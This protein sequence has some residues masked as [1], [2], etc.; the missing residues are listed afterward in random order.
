MFEKFRWPQI[1]PFLSHIIVRQKGITSLPIG[2]AYLSVER[3]KQ[4][5]FMTDENWRKLDKVKAGES[6]SNII[7]YCKAKLEGGVVKM[8]ALRLMVMGGPAVGKTTMIRRLRS[9]SES[10]WWW[11]E[12]GDQKNMKL[13]ST[14]GVEL[15]DVVLNDG[16]ILETWDFGG[17]K[18]Y[19]V[20][21]QLF[22]RDFCVY[23]VMCRVND[24]PEAALKELRFW[25]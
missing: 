6:A 13:L 15:G 10:G 22:L 2:L 24:V 18:I 3:I 20:S 7:E 21:H 19:R 9:S 12:I 5:Q 16:T 11:P 23:A 4:I 25:D 14:D 1:G 8:K 17:Q